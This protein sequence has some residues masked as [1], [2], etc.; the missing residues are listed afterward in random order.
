MRDGWDHLSKFTEFVISV[1]SNPT[2]LLIFFFV[3]R[4]NVYYQSTFSRHFT[5][6][7]D[8]IIDYMERYIWSS[9]RSQLAA[10]YVG[11]RFGWWWFCFWDALCRGYRVLR[12]SLAE[13]SA[14]REMR[15]GSKETES[16]EMGLGSGPNVVSGMPSA[17][18]LRRRQGS[19]SGGDPS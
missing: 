16:L 14:V 11:M 8:W 7:V 19:S 10:I 17:F 3:W 9:L 6:G 18:E 13:I 4:V 1:L 12:A 2:W 5:L 15:R